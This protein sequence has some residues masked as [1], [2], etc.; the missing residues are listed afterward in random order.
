MSYDQRGRPGGARE[1]AE[2]EEARKG[3][4]RAARQRLQAAQMRTQL[5]DTSKI[6]GLP[7]RPN[8][9]ISQQPPRNRSEEQQQQQASS[10]KS[11]K[12][13]TISP[14]PQWPLPNDAV[15]SSGLS[16][17]IPPRSPKRLRPPQ[18]DLR[19]SS[20]EYPIQQLSPSYPQPTSRFVPP[21]HS[22]L[23]PLPRRHLRLDRSQTSPSRSHPCRR[24]NKSDVCL[25]WVRHLPLAEGLHLTIPKCLTCLRSRRSR[26]EVLGRCGHG[27]VHT[28]LAMFFLVTRTI[29][30]RMTTSSR[31]TTLQ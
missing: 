29:F 9:L 13:K 8:Q 28:H 17:I 21:A 4:V 24:C 11:G 31:M 10:S 18:Q 19:P 30:M 25:A 20:D 5:P 26:K 14:P 6:I 1:A 16:P 12:P 7:Q 27:M 22:P 2:D 23:L 3:S 15:G